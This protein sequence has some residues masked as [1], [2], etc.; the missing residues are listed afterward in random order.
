[1]R[2]R[3]RR[4]RRA[5]DALYLRNRAVN[6]PS[7]QTIKPKEKGENDMRCKGLA[8][9]DATVP[10]TGLSNSAPDR[11][12]R[13]NISGVAGLLKLAAL[14]VLVA[15]LVGSHPAAAGEGAT[16]FI[17]TLGSRGFEVLTSHESPAQKGAY[18][19]QMLRRDFDLTG[20]ARFMLGPYWRVAT[21]TQRREFRSLLP[22]YIVRFDG[23]RFASSGGQ[24]FS[25]TGSRTAD[26][27][28][29]VNSQITR[30]QGPPVE[31]DWRVDISDGRYK[32]SDVSI[33]GVSLAL[34][35][36]SEFA[37]I[38]QRNGGQVDG[39]LAT[40]REQMAS[41]AGTPSG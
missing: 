32:I 28:V 29:I 15:M 37:A 20:M 5:S 3:P 6:P 21:T 40:M 26:G 12:V 4:Q 2:G 22:E 7:R 25:V 27:A 16:D 35:H 19:Y 39:L 38:I 14:V 24:G 30:P 36:R 34:T 13:G 33:G 8:A 18:F 10:Q 9:G 17:Q 31:V 1:V 23:D 11:H 41:G